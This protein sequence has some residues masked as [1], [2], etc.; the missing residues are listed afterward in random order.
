MEEL[1]TQLD[2]DTTADGYVNPDDDV[3][4]CLTF[5]DT[6]QWRKELRSMVI[7]E[8]PSLSKPIRVETAT[9]KMTV[10]MTLNQKGVH[11]ASH[12]IRWHSVSPTIRYFLKVKMKRKKLLDCCSMLS[13]C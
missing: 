4:A 12:H 13:L 3:R 5:E 10:E 9:Q 7:D 2:S 1:V 11:V 6:D 8:T